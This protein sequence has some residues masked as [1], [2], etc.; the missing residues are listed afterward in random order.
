MSIR[1]KLLSLA[2]RLLPDEVRTKVAVHL[3]KPDCRF[4]LF[5]LRRF[6]FSPRQV[7]DVGAYRGEWARTCLDVWPHASA[8]C[9][10]P[11]Q[12]PQEALRRL[13]ND[14]APQVE[15]RQGLL[16]ADDREAVPFAE[17]GTG[18]SVLGATTAAATR[19]M[20]S[21]DRLIGD[22]LPQPDLVKID[23]QGYELEVLEGFAK[24]LPKC[25]VLQLELS[26]LPIARGAPLIH[27]VIAYL[28]GRGFV[29]FDIDELI[30][31][32]SDAAVWQID[33]L[34]CQESSPLRERRSWSEGV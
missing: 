22:G 3:G 32:P 8:L 17:V 23:V 12:L 2:L 1:S 19:P 16:G 34:F 9:I 21:I 24:N 7:L 33:A 13:S 10:E 15:I 25:G 14:Y 11:Q 31:A 27:D 18:S 5:Q 20:W 30:R 4:S 28:K 26:L 29:M 6:G